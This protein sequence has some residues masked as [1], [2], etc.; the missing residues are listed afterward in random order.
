MVSEDDSGTQKA[1]KFQLPRS[2]AASTIVRTDVDIQVAQQHPSC[3]KITTMSDFKVE[4]YTYSRDLEDNP[5]EGLELWSRRHGRNTKF[6]LVSIRR[7]KTNTLGPDLARRTADEAQQNMELIRHKNVVNFICQIQRK[8]DPCVVSE[9]VPDTLYDIVTS[10]ERRSLLT[11]AFRTSITR[12]LVSVL[13][14]LHS[15]DNVLADI[16][17]ENMCITADGVLKL[18]NILWSS[19]R[20]VSV[21]R[22]YLRY[23]APEMILVDP[24]C[25]WRADIWAIGCVVYE[26]SVFDEAIPIREDSPWWD[27]L[28]SQVQV[29]GRLCHKHK[30]MLRSKVAQEAREGQRRSAGLLPVVAREAEILGTFRGHGNLGRKMSLKGLDFKWKKFIISC[31][32]MCPH[33]RPT[34]QQLLQAFF[35]YAQ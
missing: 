4:D 30:D 33:N 16:K 10:P 32:Q 19:A 27:V 22:G 26:I 9:Y 6:P 21:D 29:L 7:F 14:H 23:R 12:Q 1:H 35:N 17:L 34:C 31:L 3:Q 18:A 25:D 5:Y 15:I 20:N 24:A 8:G 2:K 11:P 28:W 13:Q